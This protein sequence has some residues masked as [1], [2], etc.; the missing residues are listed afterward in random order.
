MLTQENIGHI[1]S[2]LYRYLQENSKF[3]GDK[4]YSDISIVTKYG[5]KTISREY[6][7]IIIKGPYYF[8][9]VVVFEDDDLL[10]M[11]S[12][13]I[14]KIITKKILDEMKGINPIEYSKSIA[15]EKLG[16]E[17][18]KLVSELD[19]KMDSLFTILIIK[20]LRKLI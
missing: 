16:S 12:G 18:V 11:M 15:L 17:K 19:F 14:N 5:E 1:N 9:V 2:T 7:N 3:L 13:N 10:E 6:P 4:S 8:E 20:E